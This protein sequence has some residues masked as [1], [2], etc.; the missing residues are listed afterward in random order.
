L[1]LPSSNTA[2]AEE[3][4]HLGFDQTVLEGE[5]APQGLPYMQPSEVFTQPREGGGRQIVT[6]GGRYTGAVVDAEQLTRNQIQ[7]AEETRDR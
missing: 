1:A 6:A 3:T 4:R 2:E 5:V 7:E